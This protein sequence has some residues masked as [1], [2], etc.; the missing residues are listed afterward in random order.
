MNDENMEISFSVASAEPFP[1]F[2]LRQNCEYLERLV[3]ED[4]AIDLTR[5]NS[6]ASVLRNHDPDHVLGTVIRA[7]IEDGKLWASIR[8]RKNDEEAGNIYRDIVDG[9]LRNVSIGYE[10]NEV[11]FSREN[12]VLYGDVTRWTPMEVSVAVGVPADPTVGFYRSINITKRK[13]FPMEEENKKNIDENAETKKKEEATPEPEKKNEPETVPE[14]KEDAEA[15]KKQESADEIRALAEIA[16]QPELANDAIRRGVTLDAFRSELKNSFTIRSF[17]TPG[18]AK[19]MEKKYSI[20]NALRSLLTGKGGEF[21]R[22]I[23]DEIYRRAGLRPNEE[24]GSIMI[25]F[26]RDTFPDSTGFDSAANVGAALVS[27]EN[28]PEMFVDYIRNKMGVKNA[29]FLTGLRNN[30]TI[31]TQTGTGSVGWV[32]DLNTDVGATK[33]TTGNISLTPKKLGAYVPTGKDLL[34]QGNP[35][36]VNL[37][38]RDLMAL[39]AQKLSITMLKGNAASPAITGL[40]TAAGV[41]TVTIADVAAATWQDMLKFGACVEGLAYTGKLEFIMSA[42]DKQTFKGISKDTGSGRFLCEDNQIDGYAVAVDGNLASGEIFF[43]DFSNIIVGQWGGLEIMIDPY[44]YARSGGVEVIASLVA[45]IAVRNPQT[46]VK[47]VASA[48]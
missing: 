4:T 40:A 27:T 12:G 43:G 5:L 21:E 29:T 41:Q 3:I 11:V 33:P 15:K 2:S 13:E 7:W 1:R 30:I 25:P 39:I 26:S 47:R 34:V 19:K 17:N 24:M 18:K 46:F 8:F 48:G 36:A 22:E 44:K 42:S 45:D 28:R 16:G 9:T 6:G 32:A 14:K 20:A 31:P 37:V 23:S 38:I 35:D 10:Q